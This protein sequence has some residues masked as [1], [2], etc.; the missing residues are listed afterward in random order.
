MIE[1]NYLYLGALFI[2]TVIGDPRGNLHPVVLIGNLI[3]FL[4]KLLLK[5]NSSPE[6][7]KIAGFFLCLITVGFVYAVSFGITWLLSFADPNIFL[8][9]SMLLLSFTISPHALR[10]SAEEI[11]LLLVKGDIVE[12][13]HKVSW[14]VG[15]DTQNLDEAEVTRATVE[16]VAENITD[17]IIS[18][19][20]YA[21]IGGVP[22]ACAYRAVNTLDS[23]VGYKN[24]KYLDFGVV[25]ARFDDLCNFIP[26]RITAFLVVFLS[27][28][29]PGYSGKK[30]WQILWRDAS[31][32][33]SPNSG[34]AEAPVAG[35]LGV[36]LGGCNYYF[37]RPSFR[38]YMGD[39][40]KILNNEHIAKTV[41]LM[42]MVTVAFALIATFI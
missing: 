25:S 10:K 35:A 9:G 24:D 38:E 5:Q 17:G 14:I 27:A 34:Y 1:P 6:K 20:F 8:F 4:E 29:L 12:A 26:A 36:R 37:G 23:M 39:S 16:T 21:V 22:L 32:H 42:Y 28:L 33:P 11:R 15:R 7:K 13:R 18:P 40:E 41:A 19:L 31:K 3:S 2:D 30:A